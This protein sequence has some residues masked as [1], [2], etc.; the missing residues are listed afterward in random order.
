M[1][2]FIFS[3][4]NRAESQEASRGIVFT[5][6]IQSTAIR[7]AISKKLLE[8]GYKWVCTT[9]WFNKANPLLTRGRQILDQTNDL[10]AQ[11]EENEYFENYCL[12][13]IP[14]N[15]DYPA[16]TIGQYS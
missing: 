15:E 1:A 3:E 14:P 13:V 16:I 10:I 4:Y 2:K 12:I 7:N 5:F 6:D 8:M 11:Y 9:T